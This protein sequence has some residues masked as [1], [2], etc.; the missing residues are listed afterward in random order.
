MIHF[1]LPPLSVYVESTQAGFLLTL[2]YDAEPISR[3]IEQARSGLI[4]IE[5][6]FPD[7]NFD[8]WFLHKDDVRNV[9]LRQSALAIEHK[10]D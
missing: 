6:E 4:K 2:V 3:A 5:D 7:V 9:H 8:T 1:H 10:N